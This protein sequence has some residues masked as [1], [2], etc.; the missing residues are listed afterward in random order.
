MLLIK[1]GYVKT[2]AGH[3]I[4]KGCVLIND[5]GKIEKVAAKIAAPKGA[6]VI[7]AGGKLVTPGCVDAHCHIGMLDSAM[8]WEGETLHRAAVGR[9]ITAKSVRYHRRIDLERAV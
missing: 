7:D 5:E 2:M 9:H 3:D 6:K 4:E 1:N 8:R